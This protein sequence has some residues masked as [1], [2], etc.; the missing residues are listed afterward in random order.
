MGI[1]ESVLLSSALPR[2]VKASH[3]MHSQQASRTRRFS[4]ACTS[5]L[6]FCIKQDRIVSTGKTNFLPRMTLI[7]LI[8]ADKPSQNLNAEYTA[9]QLRSSHHCIRELGGKFFS[10]P[11]EENSYNGLTIE[12]LRE[13]SKIRGLLFL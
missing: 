7:K 10:A 3:T 8:H 9:L 5:L 12:V 6:S 1:R 2:V 4:I 11:E 13:D